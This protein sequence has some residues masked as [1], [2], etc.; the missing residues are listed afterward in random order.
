[1]RRAITP[2][3]ALT[4]C[5]PN[6]PFLASTGNVDICQFNWVISGVFGDV[7]PELAIQHDDSH[8]TLTVIEPSPTDF[9][10][11]YYSHFPAFSLAVPRLNTDGYW[12]SLS[13]APDDDPTGA[14]A[15]TADLVAIVGFSLQWAVWAER[16][17]DLALLHTQSVGGPWL[18]RSVPF[19]PVEGRL[20]TSPSPTSSCR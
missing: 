3:L 8:I 15:Y 17:W 5:L 19:V 10:H 11:R 16:R 13:F 6:W 2:A 7:L 4:T 1:M 9:Y 18:A 14:I 12:E 20:L